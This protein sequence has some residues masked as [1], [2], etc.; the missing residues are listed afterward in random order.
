MTTQDDERKIKDLFAGRPLK[1]PPP[2]IMRDYVKEVK[3]KIS[4][5]DPGHFFGAPAAI[6]SAVALLGLVGV[7]VYMRQPEIRKEEV[8]HGVITREQ[9]NVVQKVKALTEQIPDAPQKP[10][11]ESV[12]SEV[13]NDLFILEMLGETEGLENVIPSYDDRLAIDMEFLS[14]IGA[15]AV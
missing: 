3:Q 4:N 11:I 8:P 1:P 14:E 13:S 15:P 10:D 2:A 6:F 7:L 9:E 12:L 5:P